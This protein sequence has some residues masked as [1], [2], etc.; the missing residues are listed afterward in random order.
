MRALVTRWRKVGAFGR[1]GPRACEVQAGRA[2]GKLVIRIE[3][4]K[5]NMFVLAE[6]EDAERLAWQIIKECRK[7]PK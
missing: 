4:G 2:S 5:Q 3:Q 7:L 1:T 6:R